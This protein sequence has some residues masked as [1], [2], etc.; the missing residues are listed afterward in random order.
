M[1]VVRSIA[2]EGPPLRWIPGGGDGA[3]E[4]AMVGAG[5]RGVGMGFAEGE[6]VVGGFGVG[7]VAP[8]GDGVGEFAPFGGW[9][10]SSWGIG[11]RRTLWRQA[12]MSVDHCWG[13]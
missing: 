5:S 10:G 1:L 11:S 12:W 2:V 7:G 6:E 13:E 8:D 4:R 9:G 3:M